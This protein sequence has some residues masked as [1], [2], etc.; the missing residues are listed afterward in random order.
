MI[1]T[2]LKSCFENTEPKL[3]NYKDFKSFPPEAIEEELSEAL[4]DCGDSLINL[5]ISLYQG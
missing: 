1:C 4:I 2:M 5:I 3:L